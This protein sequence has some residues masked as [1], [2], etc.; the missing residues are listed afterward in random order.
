[1][2]LLYPVYPLHIFSVSL[3]TYPMTFFQ[4]PLQKYTNLSTLTQFHFFMDFT[5]LKTNK[6]ILTL[7]IA[8]ST[9]VLYKTF[10]GMHCVPLKMQILLKLCFYTTEGL[11]V[12]YIEE[13]QNIPPN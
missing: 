9:F 1:M 2:T 5:N 4:T 3:V 10:I 12:F 7:Q 8:S 11:F 13:N 6:Q